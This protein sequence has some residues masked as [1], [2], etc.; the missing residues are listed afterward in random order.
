MVSRPLDLLFLGSGNVFAADRYWGSFLVNDRYLF[1]ACPVALP[2]LKRAGVALDG[3]EAVF[4]SHFHA[5]HLFGLPFLLFEYAHGAPRS[6]DLTIIGPPGIEA[7]VR[8]ITQAGLPNLIDKDAGYRLLFREVED[9]VE[10]EVAGVTYVAREVVHVPDFPCFGYR[11]E[12]D[13]RTIAY[14][15]DSTLCD[16]LVDLSAGADVFVVE[17]SIW[18]EGK[19]GPHMG[20]NDIRELRRRLG[21]APQFVLTHLDPGERDLRIDNTVLATDLARISVP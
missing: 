20:P 6:K 1:D 19:S 2:H 9:G 10:A 5:D 13:G 15:G 7:R 8:T 18:D 14:S 17:C 4:I 3:I 11:A 21:P 16:A 12:I